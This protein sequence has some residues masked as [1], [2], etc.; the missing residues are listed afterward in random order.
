MHVITVLRAVTCFGLIHHQKM[1]THKSVCVCG[2]ARRRNPLILSELAKDGPH[3][4][5][6]T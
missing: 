2:C 1:A 5:L 4:S 3:K 6:G